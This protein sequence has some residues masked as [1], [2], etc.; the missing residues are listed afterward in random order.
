MSRRKAIASCLY[1]IIGGL[2]IIGMAALVVLLSGCKVIKEVPVEIVKE[3]VKYVDR[4][5]TDS[6]YQHDSIYIKAVEDTIYEYRDKYI[7]KYEFVRDTSYITKIDS[8]PIVVEVEKKLSKWNQLKVNVG[9]YLIGLILLLIAI[10]V[11][12]CFKKK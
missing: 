2:V 5:Q 7:Y 8:I 9:G 10:V 3:R 11:G 4:L 6:I 1:A 12:Y